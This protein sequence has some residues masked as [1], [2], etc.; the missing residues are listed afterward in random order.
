MHQDERISK[1]IIS[2]ILEKE[3]DI[4]SFHKIQVI[5]HGNSEN[6][7]VH[8]IVDKDMSIGDSH[9]LC[10]NLESTIKN[11]YGECKVDLHLEPCGK[12]CEICAFSCSKRNY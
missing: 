9:A 1:Q 2:Y 5:R 4:V 3:K 8:L 6:I 12:H 7:K 10:H 11:Q